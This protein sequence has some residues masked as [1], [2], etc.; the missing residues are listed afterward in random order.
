MNLYL[1]VLYAGISLTVVAALAAIVLCVRYDEFFNDNDPETWRFPGTCG[2]HVGPEDK[3]PTHD[4][5]WERSVHLL[6]RT[7]PTRNMG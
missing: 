7:H 3:E 4:V 5:D 2:I 6:Q 1:A